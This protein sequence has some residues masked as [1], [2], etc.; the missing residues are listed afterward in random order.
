NTRQ[1]PTQ[2]KHRPARSAPGHFAVG[3]AARTQAVGPQVSGQ[4][5]VGVIYPD[6]ALDSQGV[7]M[8]RTTFISWSVALLSGL[9]VA[10]QVT[11][12]GL[13]GRLIGARNTGLLVT[14]SGGL[15]ALLIILALTVTRQ[16][17]AWTQITRL[18]WMQMGLAGLLGIGILTGIAFAL[19]RLG[20]AAGLA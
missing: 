8:D 1:C 10:V 6:V 20:V 14:A 4:V 17:I 12:N 2:Q 11:L 16:D 15:M 3:G 13:A 9:A 19:P 18:T 5:I 7:P